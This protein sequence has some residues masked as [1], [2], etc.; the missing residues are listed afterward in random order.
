MLTAARIEDGE[1][2]WPISSMLTQQEMDR[3]ATSIDITPRAPPFTRGL[4]VSDLL[5]QP[6]G[7]VHCPLFDYGRYDD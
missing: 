3:F 2:V 1:K 7:R 4:V 6:S 5:I